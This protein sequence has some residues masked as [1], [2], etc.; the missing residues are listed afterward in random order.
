MGEFELAVLQTVWR[1]QPCTE[2]HVWN[3]IRTQRDVARTTVLKAMQ[4]LESKGL[5][6]RVADAAP[7]QYRAAVTE[8]RVLP[9][10]VERFVS[11]VLGG[12]A[13]PLVAYLAGQGKLSA[14]ELSAL[15]AIANKLKVDDSPQS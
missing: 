9:T 14:K 4:R 12:S 3:L 7:V 15:R 13:E 1:S 2:R 6:V 10:L 5:L 11:G 8:A